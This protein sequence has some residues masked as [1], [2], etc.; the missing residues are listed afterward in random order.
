MPGVWVFSFFGNITVLK[1]VA[2]S[3]SMTKKVS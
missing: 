3:H 1:V 2:K